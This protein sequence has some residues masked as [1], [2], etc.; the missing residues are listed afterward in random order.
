[1]LFKEAWNLI[2]QLR[3][4]IIQEIK[5]QDKLRNDN[6]QLQHNHQIDIR[7][8][9]QIEEL[10]NKDLTAAKDQIRTRRNLF[11]FTSYDFGFFDE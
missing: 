9:E 4:E 5:I 2:N 6:Q 8:R 10:L 7:E 1:L 3:E 11:L